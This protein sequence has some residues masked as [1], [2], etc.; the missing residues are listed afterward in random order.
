VKLEE[1]EVG[2]EST[3]V[4]LST[5]G[6][7]VVVEVR[8]TVMGLVDVEAGPDGGRKWRPAWRHS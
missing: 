2:A 8:G 4:A 6:C 3:G 7:P 1:D 5:V